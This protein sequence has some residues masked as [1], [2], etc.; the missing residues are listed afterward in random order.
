MNKKLILYTVLLVLPFSIRA[1]VGINTTN[2]QGI[3]HIDPLNNTVGSTNVSD[4]I[5]VT[6]DGSV[7]IGIINPTAKLHIMGKSSLRIADGTQSDG[8]VFTSVNNMGL[9][10]WLNPDVSSRVSTCSIVSTSSMNYNLNVERALTG[11][12]TLPVNDLG[13]TTS[14][15]NFIVPKGKYLVVINQ[16]LVGVEYGI[17]RIRNASNGSLIFEKPYSEWLVGSVAYITFAATTS[18]YISFIP[19]YTGGAYMQEGQMSGYTTTLS[20]LSLQ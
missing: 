8:Y 1:Q 20:F 10:R 15:N 5:I 3:L 2:P 11:T 16:D 9:G 19:T 18:F 13:F 14:G 17:F 12:L 6:S 7:G 4:D